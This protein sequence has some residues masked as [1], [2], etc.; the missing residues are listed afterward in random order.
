[1]KKI[2]S[3]YSLYILLIFLL[4][5]LI[6]PLFINFGEQHFSFLAESFIK[7]RL[8]ISQYPQAWND[9]SFFKGRYFWPQGPFPAI[10]LLPFSYIFNLFGPFFYQKYLQVPL[11]LGIFYLCV[12]IARRLSYGARD[13]L[14]IAIA[15]VFASVF[16]NIAIVP[17]SWQFSQVIT[18]FLIFY[19][20]Y[21]YLTHKRYLILGIIF[22]LILL[23]RATASLGIIFFVLECLI[24]KKNLASKVRNFVKLMVPFFA[25][26][27]ILAVY[28]YARFGNILEQGYSYQLAQGGVSKAREY[29]LFALIHIP[30]NLYYFLIAPPLPVLK[31]GISR[32]LT[33]PFVKSD[34][35]GMSIFFTS[36]Y[37]VYL[38][39]LKYKDKVSKFL[40][41]TV[42]IIALP[43]LMYYG[44]GMSLFGYR[45]SLDFLPYLFLLL[46]K[47]YREQKGNLSPGF[48][49]VIILSMVFN[50]YLLATFTK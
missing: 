3:K 22:G 15:F 2:K 47:N 40:W 49:L 21:E 33:F 6:A 41:I 38:A 9:A 1:M 24:N 26:G 17:W 32:V 28:N 20:I 4:S 12:T 11:V 35:W 44:I 42:L 39:F 50:L 46:F 18:V 19:A 37:F 30:G 31:D 16:T 10:I 23:T 29:G 5:L 43:I 13:S 8:D 36:P 7:G 48:K 25:A 34:I 27:L 45:Y 14:Y